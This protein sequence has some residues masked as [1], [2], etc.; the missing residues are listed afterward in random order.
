MK[1]TNDIILETI[2]NEATAKITKLVRKG[3][4]RRT[5][6]EKVAEDMEL[7]SD[8]TEAVWNSV[9]EVP[10]AE[11]PGPEHLDPTQNVIKF[12]EPAEVDQAT[13]ILMLA[14]IPWATKYSEKCFIH[15]DC[16]EKLEA[17]KEALK[18]KWD[19]LETANRC[20]AIIEFD[21]LAEYAKVLDFI[22]KQ[23][24][25]VNYG[26]ANYE[27]SEDVSDELKAKLKADKKK[28]PTLEDIQVK[29]GAYTAV[30][31]KRSTASAGPVDFWS[32]NSKRVARVR[33]RW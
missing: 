33:K 6:T 11:M 21:N 8:E 10:V 15:F 2:I 30:S 26:S 25:L 24:A 13:A 9:K 18:R 29:D 19:F 28:K 27:L 3:A 23:R 22:Q 17:A 32:D 16:R 1:T 12:E 5:A 20:V 7:T 31:K 4:D 14:G